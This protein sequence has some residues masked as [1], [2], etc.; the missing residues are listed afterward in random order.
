MLNYKKI[1][2]IVILLGLVFFFYWFFFLSKVDNTNIPSGNLQAQS[3]AVN[4]S[5]YDK[6]FV[7]SLLGLRS[8][9]LDV[10]VFNSKIYKALTYPENPITE[11]Y[12]M[13]SG[14]NNPFLPIG[15]DA[16]KINPSNQNQTKDI[17]TNI[18]TS[19]ENTVTA[20]TTPVITKPKPIPKNF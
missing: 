6:E 20:T 12:F 1:I 15:L 5:S 2:L 9:N 8:I 17:T 18:S 7:S 13:E 16:N 4:T 10:S 11:D 3:P 19:T 14:R